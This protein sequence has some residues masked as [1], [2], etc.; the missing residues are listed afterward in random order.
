MSTAIASAKRATSRR[1]SATK[2]RARSP[3]RLS[4]PADLSAR[5]ATQARKQNLDVGA[6][7]RA[8][9]EAHVC[10]LE[11]GEALAEAEAWQSREAWA[12]WEKIRRGDRQDVPMSTFRE[13]TERA[14]DALDARDRRR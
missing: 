6:A 14:L 13:H 2:K 3:L 8:F 5:L 9:L 1:P 11:E 10:R 4:I 12:T 7:A